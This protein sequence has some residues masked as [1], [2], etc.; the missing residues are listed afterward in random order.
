[1]K[2][3]LEQLEDKAAELGLD[4]KSVIKAEGVAGT[5]LKRWRDGDTTCRQDTAEKLFE[6]MELMAK[7]QA[8]RQRPD[9]TLGQSA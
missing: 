2:T 5:T 9:R 7:E 4:L 3:L 8:D 6:R 1:M